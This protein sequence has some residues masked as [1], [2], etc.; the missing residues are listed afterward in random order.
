MM[1]EQITGRGH[2][3][4]RTADQIQAVVQLDGDGSELTA[5]SENLC[6]VVQLD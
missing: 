6:G 4:E 3:E 2:V 1:H 5:G